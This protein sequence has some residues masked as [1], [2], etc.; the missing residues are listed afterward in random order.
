MPM[1]HAD[2]EARSSDLQVGEARSSDPQVSHL[3]HSYRATAL[4]SCIGIIH[5]VELLHPRRLCV[6]D[7]LREPVDRSLLLTDLMCPSLFS[8][9]PRELVVNAA[10]MRYIG[11]FTSLI[12][13]SSTSVI[14]IIIQQQGASMHAMLLG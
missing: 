2:G 12:I 13:L 3:R 1:Y 11:S 14:I 9:A 5:R 4:S 6:I 7:A 10:V 8:R